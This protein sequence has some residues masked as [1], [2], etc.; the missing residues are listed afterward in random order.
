MRIGLIL[1][2]WLLFTELTG[3]SH[4]LPAGASSPHPARTVKWKTAEETYR[5]LVEYL[6]Q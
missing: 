3:F 1:F 4:T 6:E 5:R 2:S